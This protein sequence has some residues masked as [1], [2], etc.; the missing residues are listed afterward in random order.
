MQYTLHTGDCLEVL[1]TIPE[2]SID[3]CITDPPYELSFMGN[4]WDGSGISFQKETWE[5]V[6]RVLKPGATIMV[7]GGTRTFHRIAVAIEDAG[8]ILRDVFM[9]LHGQGFP[10]SYNVAKAISAFEKVGTSQPQALRKARMGDEYKPTGQVDYRKGRMFGNIEEDTFEDELTPT[11][12]QWQG[13]GT[14]LKPSYEPIIVAMKPTDGTFANNAIKWGVS[15]YWIDGGRIQGEPVPINKLEQWSGFGQ[16]EK[17]D[18]EQEINTKG[19]HPSN[20]LHDGSNEVLNLLPEGA[21]RFF[22][23]AKASKKEKSYPVKNNHPT[24]KP[25]ELI[26][27]L[28]RLTRTPTGGTVIDPFMGSG[29]CG[30]ASV[31]EDRDFIGIDMDENYVSIAKQRIE[32]EI[33]NMDAK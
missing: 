23:C 10:K 6:F 16:K 24:V 28:V 33:E 3:T 7:F 4:K 20:V 1:K 17:P 18:Y 2:N 25:L 12:R 9:W 31:I 27:Y 32:H 29:T 5:E 8:F 21:D 22:Y 11:A 26:K 13:F 19:R 30:V 15:G 14:Q